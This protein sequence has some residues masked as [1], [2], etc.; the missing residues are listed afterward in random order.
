[1]TEYPWADDGLV[2]C[3]SVTVMP[4]ADAAIHALL[5]GAQEM[6]SFEAAQEASWADDGLV[7]HTITIQTDHHVIVWEDNGYLGAS[8]EQFRRLC[9]PGP[10]GSVFVNVNAVSRLLLGEDGQ[11]TREFDP[12]FRRETDEGEGDPLPAEA[13]LDWSMGRHISSSLLLIASYTGLSEPFDPDW[14]ESPRARH[15]LLRY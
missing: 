3:I 4:S 5:P 7:S 6:A 9:E 11:I 13:A 15:W 10:A 14:F 2:A 8:E 1:M 12:L